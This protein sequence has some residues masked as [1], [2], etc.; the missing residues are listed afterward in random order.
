MRTRGGSFNRYVYANN[1]PYRYIDP[2]GRD[3][4][5]IFPLITPERSAAAAQHWADKQ[6]ATG[7]VFYAVPRVVAT[8]LSQNIEGVATA[9]LMMKG[10][11]RPIGSMGGPRAGLPHTQA[12]KKLRSIS[13]KLQMAAKL[14]VLIVKDR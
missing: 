2:D 6:V 1:N 3:P 10:A 12:A 11:G 5:S 14:L 8:V 7:N 9:A 13:I 4:D